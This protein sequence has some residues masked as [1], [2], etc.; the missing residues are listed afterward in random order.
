MLFHYILH[1]AALEAMASE[2]FEAMAKGIIRAEVGLRL[3]LSR[4][5]EA[6]VR[7][8]SRTTTGQTVLVP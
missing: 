4:A 2:S 8:E 3:P 7:L 1:R 6:H 5:A